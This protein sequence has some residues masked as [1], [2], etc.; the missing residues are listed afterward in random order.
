MM[1]LSTYNDWDFTTVWAK[2]ATVNDGYP[3][4][5]WTG[6]CEHDLDSDGVSAAIENA[7]PNSGDAN[8]DGLLDSE[9]SN[10]TSLVNNVTGKYL[11]LEVDETCTLSDVTVAAA[12]SIAT[13]DTNYQYTNG[14]LNFSASCG[15]PGV[16]ISVKQYY[17]GVT[18]V[19]GL[20]ARKF[21]PN[22]LEYKTVTGHSLSLA[23]ESFGGQNT[24]V[25][26]YTVT[27]G[28]DLDTDGTVDGTIID[29]I[30]LAS[31]NAGTPNTGFFA[32]A[33]GSGAIASIGLTIIVV[34]GIA[35]ISFGII[36]VSRHSR[37]R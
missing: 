14:L 4:L 22:T 17:H 36:Y 19:S 20:V 18:S 32:Q 28:D 16:T 6:D 25:L 33:M 8:Y 11:T 34:A 31:T 3:C 10:V 12:G 7:A 5:R 29:P 35:S 23:I 37:N 15:T 9:Q 26:A 13:K 30:G 27:D 21:N 24:T 1:E 2:S